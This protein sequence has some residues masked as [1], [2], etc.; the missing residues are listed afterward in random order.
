[1]SRKSIDVLNKTWTL[2][3]E[4]DVVIN[5]VLVEDCENEIGD[6]INNNTKCIAINETYLST[7]IN[8]RRSINK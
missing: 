8:N 1:M 3:D 2:I 7:T 6:D 4:K 5:D